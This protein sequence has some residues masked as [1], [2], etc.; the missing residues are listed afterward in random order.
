M[1]NDRVIAQTQIRMND[2]RRVQHGSVD[3]WATNAGYE[4]MGARI[5]GLHS[6]GSGLDR[7]SKELGMSYKDFA[8]E[9]SMSRRGRTSFNCTSTPAS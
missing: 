1:P 8:F 4:Y 7:A 6:T 3:R 9:L 5:E 2:A